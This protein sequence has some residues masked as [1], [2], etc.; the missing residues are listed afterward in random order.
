M[1]VV[2]LPNMSQWRRFPY[3]GQKSQKSCMTVVSAVLSILHV[4]FSSSVHFD[5]AL[6]GGLNCEESAAISCQ[7]RIA[8]HKAISANSRL[9]RV[10]ELLVNG[11]ATDCTSNLLQRLQVSEIWQQCLTKLKG[12]TKYQTTHMALWYRK[13]GHGS[14]TLYQSVSKGLQLVFWCIMLLIMFSVTQS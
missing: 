7:R 6:L 9:Y 3:I 5:L 8:P 13:T 12:Q 14:Q 4:W 11:C 1:L 2:C 10:E